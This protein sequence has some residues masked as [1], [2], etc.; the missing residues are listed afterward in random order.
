MPELACVVW[1]RL[2]MNVFD[3]TRQILLGLNGV[4]LSCA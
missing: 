2:E 4:E 3:S 1:S